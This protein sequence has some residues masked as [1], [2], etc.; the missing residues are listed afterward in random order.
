MYIHAHAG[1][2]CVCIHIY[3]RRCVCVDICTPLRRVKSLWSRRALR[4]RYFT[5]IHSYVHV[6]TAYMLT[7]CAYVYMH[8]ST[9]MRSHTCTHTQRVCLCGS[10]CGDLHAI[11]GEASVCLVLA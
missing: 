6:H 7:Y 10:N 1:M 9:H 2:L 4:N 8:L 5:H 3:E 11:A